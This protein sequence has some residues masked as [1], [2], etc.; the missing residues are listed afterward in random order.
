LGEVRGG[1]KPF[2]ARPDDRRLVSAEEDDDSAA[3]DDGD[4]H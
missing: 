1:G 2:R 4:A 3:G